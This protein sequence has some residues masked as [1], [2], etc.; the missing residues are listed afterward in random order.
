MNA[1]YEHTRFQVPSREDVC[2][3]YSEQLGIDVKTIYQE[4]YVD[5]NIGRLHEWL[6][7]HSPKK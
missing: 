4:L 6:D 2:E 3:W 7:E 1:I 5:G